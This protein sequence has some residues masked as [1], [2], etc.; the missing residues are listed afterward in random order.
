MDLV[1]D[2]SGFEHGVILGYQFLKF[3]AV[4]KATS[5]GS[6]PTQEPS[7]GG[8][9]TWRSCFSFPA[10]D[11]ILHPVLPDFLSKNPSLQNKNIPPP[12]K[13]RL[14]FLRDI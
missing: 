14:K 3:Q 9:Q 4:L 10:V 13:N 11:L 5:G 8:E 2:I 1:K 6:N 12:K 7:K